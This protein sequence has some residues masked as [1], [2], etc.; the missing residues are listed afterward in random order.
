LQISTKI[1]PFIKYWR[2]A[3]DIM[4]YFPL[5]KIKK[6]EHTI[7]LVSII[8]LKKDYLKGLKNKNARQYR[9]TFSCLVFKQKEK[10]IKVIYHYNH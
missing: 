4:S 2:F 3:I 8:L 9:H 6:L 7:L 5:K 1:P 10:E